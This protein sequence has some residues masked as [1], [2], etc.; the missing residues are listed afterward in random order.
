M[1]TKK[2]IQEEEIDLGNF[3]Q[4]IGNLFERL[5][6]F[7]GKVLREAYH[8]F[9]LSLIFLKKHYI[10]LGSALIVGLILGFVLEKTTPGVYRYDMI[11]EPHYSGAYQ[12]SERIQ[13]YNNLIKEGDSV[14]LSKLFDIDYEDA[15]SLIGFEMRRLEDAKDVFDRYD[16]YVKGKDS[17]TLSHLNFIRFSDPQFSDFDSKYYAF[18]M[19]LSKVALKKNIQ[20]NLV[21]DLSNNKTLEKE[22]ERNLNRLQNKFDGF[23]K[24]LR[25]VDSLRKSNREIALLKAKNQNQN[26]SMEFIEKVDRNRSEIE[27]FEIQEGAIKSIDSIKIELNKGRDIY[28]IV[29]P[30]KPLGKAEINLFNYNLVKFPLIAFSLVLFF[31]I[32]RQ[33]LSYL[34]RYK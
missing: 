23:K 5:F 8:Y 15:N 2:P 16:E 18:R 29:T 10:V 34:D 28:K 7:L 9:I 26:N 12:M 30:F 1:S 32:F 11:V 19:E 3:F 6:K 17:L 31:L 20:H 25:D 27:L 13:Y 14:S 4:Q 33:F 21:A 22:K 24:I